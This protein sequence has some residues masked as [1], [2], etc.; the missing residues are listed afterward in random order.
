MLKTSVNPFDQ[1]YRAESLPICV[2]IVVLNFFFFFM[3][4][5]IPVTIAIFRNVLVCKAEMAERFGKT[6]L[7]MMMMMMI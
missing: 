4:R 1:P 3:N 5:F 6:R 2:L 7:G